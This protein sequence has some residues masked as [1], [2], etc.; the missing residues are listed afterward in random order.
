[1]QFVSIPHIPAALA[2]GLWGTN[3]SEVIVGAISN[4]DDIIMRH[5]GRNLEMLSK[6]IY[7]LLC[8]H[9]LL[10]KGKFPQLV[11][12]KYH[13]LYYDRLRVRSICSNLHVFSTLN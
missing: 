12:A 8:L 2:V 5:F 1:M 9:N 13:I 3:S 7:F 4:A 6:S 10:Y 11:L